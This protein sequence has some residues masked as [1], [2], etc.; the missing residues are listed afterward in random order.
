[1]NWEK[2][3]IEDGE[4]EFG[5]IYARR[6]EGKTQVISELPR[7]MHLTMKKVSPEKNNQLEELIQARK[8]FCL[9]SNIQ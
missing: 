5:A 3:E 2:Y 7:G 1:M 6:I 8:L 4:E 9:M